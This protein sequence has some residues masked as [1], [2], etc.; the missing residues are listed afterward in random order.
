MYRTLHFFLYTICRRATSLKWVFLLGIQA[1][2]ISNKGHIYLT[3]VNDSGS[4]PICGGR[5]QTFWVCADLG[6]LHPR[7]SHRR[8]GW[9]RAPARGRCRRARYPEGSWVKW[10]RAACVRACIATHARASP[11]CGTG[12]DGALSRTSDRSGRTVLTPLRIACWRRSP[13][14]STTT[15]EIPGRGLSDVTRNGNHVEMHQRDLTYFLEK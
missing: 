12:G 7:A 11:V 14:A 2:V 4:R 6:R 5:P 15:A 8:G 3:L 13:R 1:S 9:F 10:A